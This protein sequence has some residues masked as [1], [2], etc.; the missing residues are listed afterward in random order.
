MEVFP[1]LLTFCEGN[2]P[3]TGGSSLQKLVAPSFDVFFDVQLSKRLK[4]TG[5]LPVIWETMTVIWR[6]CN[7]LKRHRRN[8]VKSRSQY[9]F[10]IT[11]TS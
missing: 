11:M 10:N 8:Q 5:V 6:H 3:V 7:G 9:M 1:A 2:Q 4:K